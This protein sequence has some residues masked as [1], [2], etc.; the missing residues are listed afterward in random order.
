MR[1]V[2]HE[3]QTP[4]PGSR[5]DRYRTLFIPLL[6][7][8][9][10]VLLAL[11]FVQLGSEVTEG[12]TRGFDLRLSLGA[13]AL[14]AA[15]PWLAEVG[16]DLSGLG[17]MTVLSLFIL[18]T[19]GYLVLVNARTTALLV[20]TSALTGSVLIS[21]FKSVFSR[22]RPDAS[23]AGIVAQGLS[24]PSG[25]ASMSAIVFLTLGALLASVHTRLAERVYIFAIAALMTLLV[26][27]SRIL[28]G[29]HWATDV[30]GGW[31]FGTAWA[32]VWLLLAR[33]LDR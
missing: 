27:V 28:L 18:A 20:A 9:A 17:S 26:G 30:L 33:R 16:R 6:I 32:L 19:A 31:A 13:Q 21:V 15:H 14:R 4:P 10:S 29:V 11:A 7:G 25:H 5:L 3:N 12:D 1:S 23:L 24:F 2:H 8:L 22:M